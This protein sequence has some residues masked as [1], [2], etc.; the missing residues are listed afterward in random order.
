MFQALGTQILYLS[1]ITSTFHLSFHSF[2]LTFP[3]FCHTLSSCSTPPGYTSSLLFSFLS[4]CALPFHDFKAEYYCYC[5]FL[6]PKESF[7]CSN[8]HLND[9]LS[10]IFYPSF[11]FHNDTCINWIFFKNMFFSSDVLLNC[12]NGL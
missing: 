5:Q 9:W 7:V 11:L 12:C 4:P 6:V 10:F 1:T 8:T 2:L 3:I